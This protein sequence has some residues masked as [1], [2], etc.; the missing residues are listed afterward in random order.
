MVG[1]FYVVIG[2]AIVVMLGALVLV[3]RLRK[4]A[5]GGRIGRVVNVLAA[6]VVF[7]LTGYLAA[8]FA[9]ALPESAANLLTAVVFLFGAVFVVIVLRLIETLVKQVF[10]ELEL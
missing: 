2:L 1:V 3:V 8:P 9:P 5:R 7:F 6:F 10:E 4:I